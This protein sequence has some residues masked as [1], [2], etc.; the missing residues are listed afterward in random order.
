M[1]AFIYILIGWVV[2]G[3][4]LYKGEFVTG[5]SI[6]GTSLLAPIAG[7]GVLYA[8]KTMKVEWEKIGSTIIGLLL[9]LVAF[10]LGGYFHLELFGA[11]LTGHMWA[12]IG[13]II[14]AFFTGRS[15]G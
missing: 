9:F 1:F 13:V 7:G 14:G 15:D 3:A 6:F 12:I 5:L 8:L 2:A 4:I 11:S 10:W